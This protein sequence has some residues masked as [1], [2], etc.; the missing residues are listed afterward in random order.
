MDK[1]DVVNYLLNKNI[2]ISPQIVEAIPNQLTKEEFYT[3]VKKIE[4]KDKK[5]ERTGSKVVILKNYEEVHKKREIQ[6]FTAYFRNRY[7]SLKKILSGRTELQNALSISRLQQKREREEI[8]LIVIIN[9]KSTTKNGNIILSLED[10]TGSIDA[11]I[12]KNNQKLLDCAKDLVLDEVVGI[13]GFLESNAIFIKEII[14]PDI[15]LT[16]HLKQCEDDV[17]ALFISDIHYGLN[18]FLKEDFSNFIKWL[19]LESEERKD[20]AQKVKYLFIVGDFVEGIGIYPG[21]EKDLLVKDIY[22]QYKEATDLIK[23]IPKNIDIIICGGNHDALR[24]AEPQPIFSEDIT[25]PLF[26]MENVTLTSNPS[27]VNIHAIGESPGFN[28]LLYHG[29]SFIYYSEEVESIRLA[30]GQQRPD[31]IMKFLLQKRHLAPTH[32]SNLYMPDPDKDFLVIDPVPDI[33][34]SGHIH[35]TSVGSYKNVT[36]INASCWATQTRDQERRGI[37]PDPAKVVA[38]NLKTREVQILDFKEK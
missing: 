15:P 27:Y 12:T 25:K 20:I 5:V 11:I 28:V 33:F 7:N 30:G 1:R 6:D 31:L 24:M 32:T 19:N 9:K 10:V 22:E 21:Q 37:T 26:E 2:L 14:F 4:I 17:Y 3:F 23:Q 36:T 8:S 29:A 35:R 38:V 18:N 16:H 13:I 34:A